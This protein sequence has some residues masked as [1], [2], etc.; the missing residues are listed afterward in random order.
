[1][2]RHAGRNQAIIVAHSMGN[3]IARYFLEYSYGDFYTQAHIAVAPPFL[4]ACTALD[5]L[6]N[7]YQVKCP[8]PTLTD[9]FTEV[10]SSIR[11]LRQLLPL[12][13]CIYDRHDQLRGCRYDGMWAGPLSAAKAGSGYQLVT[14]LNNS[15]KTLR[16]MRRVEGMLQPAAYVAGDGTVTEASATY[17]ARGAVWVVGAPHGYLA[18]SPATLHLVEDVL[19]GLPS[20][21]TGGYQ[22]HASKAVMAGVNNLPRCNLAGNFSATYQLG[23]PVSF[24]LS[25]PGGAIQQATV[26]LYKGNARAAPLISTQQCAVSDAEHRLTDKPL[27]PGIYRV[28]IEPAAADSA[29]LAPWQQFDLQFEVLEPMKASDNLL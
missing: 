19:A 11:S 28:H 3:L 1:M 9:I 18:S 4:G 2:R 26:S 21:L 6:E 15:L 7:G 22:S 12:D 10:T 20:G 24:T 25:S 16:A 8:S 17:G 5:R 29:E 27:S 14:V 23:Q 13:G